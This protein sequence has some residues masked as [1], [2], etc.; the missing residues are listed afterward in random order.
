MYVR[1]HRVGIV[2]MVLLGCFA[3]ATLAPGSPG[4]RVSPPRGHEPLGARGVPS[5]ADGDGIPTDDGDATADPCTGGAVADCDDNCPDTANPDQADSDFDGIGDLCDPLKMN[6]AT[7]DSEVPEGFL[8]DSGWPFDPGAGYGWTS[9]VGTRERGIA[10]LLELDTFA[11]SWSPRTWIG[12]LPNGDYTL[13]VVCGDPAFAQQPQSVRANGVVL[14]EG[15]ATAAGQHVVETETVAVRNGRLELTI[16]SGTGYTTLNYFELTPQAPAGFLRSIDFQPAESDL[17]AGFE[18]DSGGPYDEGLGYGWNLIFSPEGDGI[19]TAEADQDIPQVLDTHAYSADLASWELAVSEG[20]YE[21]WLAVGDGGSA[22][23]PHRVVLEGLPVVLDRTTRPGEFIELRTGAFV[24]DGFLT[25]EI[26]GS[27]GGGVTALDYVV[28][29]DA[30]VDAD[31]DEHGNP[32]DNCPFVA[33]EEQEDS[34]DDGAGDACDADLD[35]DGYENPADNCPAEYNED[36]EDE[37]ADGLGDACDDCPIDAMNDVDEDGIC[38]FGDDCPHV[39][40][41]DQTDSD[42]DGLGDACDSLSVD[43]GPAAY[44]PAEGFRGDAGLRFTP[45]RGFGW[46]VPVGTRKRFTDVDPELDTLAFTSDERV[47]LAELP[48][49][50]YDVRVVVGDA[51]HAQGPHRVSAEGDS[52]IADAYTLP[53]EFTESTVNVPV[54]RGRLELLAGGGGGNTAIE[55]VEIL[56]AGIP[57]GLR[58]FSFEPAGIATPYGFEPDTGAVYDAEAGRGWSSAV[59]TRRRNRTVPRA[60]DAFAYA[61]ATRQWEVDVPLGFYQVW[62]A[63]GD[64]RYA[65]G[66]HRVIVEGTPLVEDEPTGAREFIERSAFVL[67]TDGRLTVEIGGGGGNTCLNYV[68]LQPV[69]LD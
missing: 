45:L 38:G 7:E 23:G 9:F 63:V 59:P 14:L 16:G 37:D 58:S 13:Q 28:V 54:R 21:V 33:N 35:D 61:F 29:G 10:E 24:Q 41:E 12:E 67:V 46:D 51:L 62:V 18:M 57:E 36:Q 26:G 50:D 17:P 25:I 19:P 69:E 20:Y 5:D 15:E 34:D 40:N 68:V 3:L 49:G 6:F 66:P 2:S 22:S 64:A 53:G 52:I 11:L 4:A 55:L 39:S 65:Q 30:P 43:F 44:D 60:L 27:S 8:Q 31:A 56:D 47:W 42:G 32:E 1:A 48:N